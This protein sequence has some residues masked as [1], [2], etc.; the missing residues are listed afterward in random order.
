MTPRPYLS[1]TQYSVF[2]RSPEEYRRK[3][4]LGE[5]GFQSKEMAF[6]REIANIREQGEV[7][8]DKLIAFATDLLPTYPDKNYEM[9]AIV[10][11]DKKDVMLLGKFDGVNL[12]KH[13]IGEDK[14]GK[15]WDQ[16][17][18]DKWEQLTWYAYLYWKKLKR[19]PKLITI[20]TFSCEL[21]NCFWNY[22]NW[23]L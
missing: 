1:Y 19:I 9:T 5:Q 11:V 2:R 18:V 13:I 10:K 15:H 6:G 16:K 14:T 4:L 20:T 21:P 8:E 3:Y 7:A 12:K 17:K 23:Q 22:W